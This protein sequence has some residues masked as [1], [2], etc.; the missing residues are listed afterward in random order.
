MFWS[1]ADFDEADLIVRAGKFKDA[2]I[3][4]NQ[5][6]EMQQED[7]K[8]WLE[9]GSSYSVGLQK[10]CQAQGGIVAPEIVLRHI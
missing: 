3:F 5:V 7:L 10:Y 2:S 4:Y 1:G 6:S 8:R 9:K